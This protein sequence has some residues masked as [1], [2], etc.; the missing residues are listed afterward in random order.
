[1]IF[2]I[3]ANFARLPFATGTVQN[4]SSL[5]A[6]EL[7]EDPSNEGGILLFPREKF[8][9]SRTTLYA[10]CSGGLVRLNVVAFV[11][12]QSG[13]DSDST[14]VDDSTVATEDELDNLMDEIFSGGSSSADDERDPDV[15]AMIDDVFNP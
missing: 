1:M 2:N 9:F 5:Y 3:G 12:D 10:R 6:V 7:S 8:S 4:V 11:D 13:S 14:V 15:D